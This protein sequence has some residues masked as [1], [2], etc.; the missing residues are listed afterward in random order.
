M[1]ID[2]FIGCVSKEQHFVQFAYFLFE[3]LSD[4]KD[5]NF[6]VLCFRNWWGKQKVKLFYCEE[7]FFLA[8]ERNFEE[9]GQL[10]PTVNEGWGG[11]SQVCYF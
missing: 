10:I 6:R 9:R 8:E 2:S 5:K 11:S 3:S 7:L 4:Y 1:F